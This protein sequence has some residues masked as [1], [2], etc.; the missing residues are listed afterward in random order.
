MRVLL[1]GPLVWR[2]PAD[3]NAVYLTFDDAPTGAFTCEILDILDRYG[4]KATFFCVGENVVRN[5]ETYREILLRGHSTGNHTFNHLKGWKTHVDEYDENTRKAAEVIDSGL[6]RPPYG[7]ITWRQIHRLKKDYTI[8][9]WSRLTM[10]YDPDIS[11]EDCL[12]M[13]LKE[14]QPGSIIVFHDNAK[15]VEKVRY[16]LP[17]FLEKASGEGYKFL[18]LKAR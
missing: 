13:S 1:P 11:P 18:S 6:F 14:L 10:D 7:L 12:E 9:M 3:G 16:A 8:V 2:G 5:P 4:A 15:A 17:A